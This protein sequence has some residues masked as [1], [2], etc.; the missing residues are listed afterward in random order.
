[1]ELRESPAREAARERRD[2]RGL[3]ARPERLQGLPV[4]R[5]ER[6]SAHRVLSAMYSGTASAL[7]RVTRPNEG[8]EM[9]YHAHIAEIARQRE[10][11]L[12]RRQVRHGV[13]ARHVKAAPK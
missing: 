11:E 1:S 5:A 3:A 2:R 9:N 7:F 6:R 13:H 8:G 12:R 10:H 4:A